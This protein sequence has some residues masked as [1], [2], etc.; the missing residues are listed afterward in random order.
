MSK[1]SWRLQAGSAAAADVF[2]PPDCPSIDD[3]TKLHFLSLDCHIFVD[4]YEPRFALSLAVDEQRSRLD[5]STAG[6]PCV[7]AT[8][9]LVNRD[10]D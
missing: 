1:N 5:L 9:Q 8:L 2:R 4:S 10:L 3:R 7:L 6:N